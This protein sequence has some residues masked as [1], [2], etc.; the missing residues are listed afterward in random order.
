MAEVKP[1]VSGMI[2]EVHFTDGDWIEE[3]T[4][5]YSI[6]KTTFS[7]RVQEM[8]ALLAQDLAHLNNA[9]KKIQ[10]YKSLSKQ[11]L[12]SKVEWDEME[13]KV[14]L[15][16]AMLKGDKAR[17]DAAKLDLEHCQVVA[18]IAGKASKTA[19]HAGNMA[20]NGSLVTLSKMDPLC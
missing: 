14:A 3:G 10:R 16:Q 2:T 8:E 1:L 12:I 4:L 19:L 18:P 6:D 17:L 13:T 5:L 9:K 20:S 7:I 11:D 15:Y